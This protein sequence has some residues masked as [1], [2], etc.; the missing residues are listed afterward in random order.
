M[1]NLRRR[2]FDEKGQLGVR[3]IRDVGDAGFA[4]S[5]A[6]SRICLSHL[7]V[8]PWITSGAFRFLKDK[9][10]P[11]ARVF[12]W[13]SGMSTLWW[14]QQGCEVHA[15]EDNQV[16]ADI[17]RKRLQRGSLYHLT[18]LDYVRKIGDFDPAYFNF[19]TVDGAHRLACY[20]QLL[21]RRRPGLVAIVDNTDKDRHG[22]D[23]LEMDKDLGRLTGAKTFRFP[24]YA[25][26]SFFVQETTVVVFGE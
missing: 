2:V 13:G 5:T 11:G 19:I 25:P 22:G 10:K 8:R 16:W 17:V 24:G 23:L 15:V 1:L 18:G 3:S 20:R 14:D 9:V 7:V 12:E 21:E 26:G 6:I 4:L